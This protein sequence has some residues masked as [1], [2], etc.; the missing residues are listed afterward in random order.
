MTRLAV[1]CF[2]P[3]LVAAALW[4]AG[5]NGFQIDARSPISV[6][7]VEDHP[8]TRLA[9]RRLSDYVEQVTGAR[10]QIRVGAP[11][12]ESEIILSPGAFLYS[13]PDGFRLRTRS[14][15]RQVIV[16]TPKPVGFK[17]GVQELILRM[18]QQDRALAIPELTSEHNPFIG[19]RELF[20][21]EIEWHPTD[22]E[23]K[24]LEDLRQRFS[25]L[26]W[27]DARLERYID[28]VD[29]MGYNAVMLADA[30]LIRQY[31]GE[32]TSAARG[33]AKIQA[34]FSYARDNRGMGT[35]FFLW[36]QK[37]S[38]KG[39]VEN[40]RD[41][42]QYEDMVHNWEQAIDRY[43]PFV[44]HWLLHWADPGGCKLADCTVNTPQAA[45][46]HF[47]RILR[48]KGF[49]TD[50]TFS[51]WA[52][53]WG[54]WPGYRDWTSVVSSGILHPDIGISLMRNYDYAIA[55]AAVDQ[56]RRV[57]VWGWYLNDMET[58]P[59]LHV[60]AKILENEFRR[61]H[62]SASV[63]LN[64]YSLEDNNHILNLPSLYVGGRLLW[65]PGR[66]GEDA[67]HE[68]CDAVWGP[69]SGPLFTALSAIERVRTGPGAA[70]VSHDLWP[71]A[72]MPSLAYRDAPARADVEICER[73]LAG[74]ET[75]KLNPHFVPK[76][77]LIAEP[78]E[79]LDQIRAHLRY[80]LAFARIRDH[81]QQALA[82]AREGRWEE[83]QA[84]M[85]SLP[86]L[87][88]R[89]EGSYGA[90][91]YKPYLA[92]KLFADS[93][94]GRTFKDNVAL[95]KPVTASGWYKHDPRF[96]PQMAVNGLLCEFREEGWASDSP[97][98]AWLK[99]D[100][101]TPREVREVR[102]YNRAYRREFWDNNLE[103]TPLR[104][105]VFIAGADPDPSR[106]TP[107]DQETGY[108]LLGGFE[109]WEASQDPATFR[110]VTAPAPVRA[111]F[112]K[113]VLYGA[114]GGNVT[115][116]GEVEVR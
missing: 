47:Y 25:W 94:S 11:Q 55:K 28:M 34:M 45:T 57:G 40:P 103:A 48:G 110:A 31:A 18:S 5:E 13:R 61:L 2:L 8:L 16:E 24:I 35:S 21:A 22:S 70:M 36:G 97:G 99:I 105:Q 46:N 10:P 49:A 68:F 29:A 100:L 108:Q 43:G 19:R 26:N 51:L 33:L 89:V 106:G 60:H 90:L 115:G 111:R 39:T 93:W 38:G 78:S 82:C 44:D 101:G 6:V 64:W 62:K 114:A 71:N 56:R 41:P 91:E 42:R 88:D 32:S 75:V 113:V 20:I 52:L 12:G 74:L 85:A 102:I 95:G 86:V 96:A 69:A 65:D 87:P 107:N 17:Y 112:V 3:F 37:G 14:A 72:F 79:L 66:S 98:P 30:D 104:G 53:R 80:V 54:G 77:P 7:L 59:G 109:G 63:L 23:Q 67:L 83:A 92:L 9:A 1:G 81:Y 73:A 15:R 50:V 4:T 27:T 76:L 84:G 58:N 116:T